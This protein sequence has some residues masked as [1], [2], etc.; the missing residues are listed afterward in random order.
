MRCKNGGDKDEGV[1]RLLRHVTSHTHTQMHA[2]MHTHTSNNNNSNNNNKTI[3]KETKHNSATA[4]INPTPYNVFYI[5][6]YY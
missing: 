1:A 3:T 5:L 2:C 6:F 4:K